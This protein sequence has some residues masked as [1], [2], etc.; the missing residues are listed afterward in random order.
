MGS[1]YQDAVTTNNENVAETGH[2]FCPRRDP[3]RSDQDTVQTA[4]KT[5][6]SLPPSIT[7]VQRRKRPTPT[8]HAEYREFF[9]A[10][11]VVPGHPCPWLHHAIIYKLQDTPHVDKQDVGPAACFTLSQHSRGALSTSQL[12]I[13]QPGHVASF[14][15]TSLYHSIGDFKA[16]REKSARDVT[17]CR[18]GRLFSTHS[19]VSN[20]HQGKPLSIH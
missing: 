7:G 4:Q 13:Y 6:L 9:K 20:L 10:Y 18:F 2:P 17:P 5:P 3:S 15:S 12:D 16:F 14:V 11:T 19:L 1:R 8:D